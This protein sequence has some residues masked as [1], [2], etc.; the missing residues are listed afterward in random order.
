MRQI[1]THLI[2]LLLCGTLSAHGK[3]FIF[4]HYGG[5]DGL[6]ND[7]LHDITQDRQGFIWIATHYGISRFDGKMFKNYLLTDYPEMERDDFYHAFS[8]IDSMPLFASSYGTLVAYDKI[9]DRFIDYSTRISDSKYTGNITGIFAH[10]Q[11][12]K[13]LS[14]SDGIFSYDTQNG[15]FKPVIDS[16]ASLAFLL[17]NHQRRWVGSG[18]GL[19]VY[20][21]TGQR[22]NQFARLAEILEVNNIRQL[23]PNLI[24]LASAVSESYIVEMDEDGAFKSCTMLQTPFSRISEIVV[25]KEKTLWIGTAGNGLWYAPIELPLQFKKATPKNINE[26]LLKKISALYEDETGSIW[27]GTQNSG[28][29]RCTPIEQMEMFHSSDIGLSNLYCSSFLE[30][31]E[32]GLLVGTDGQGIWE[33]DSLYQGKRHLT[34]HNGLSSNSVLSLAYFHNQI[35][36]SSWGGAII[37]YTPTNNTLHTEPIRLNRPLLTI[38]SICSNG[39]DEFLAC[40]SG[41]GVYAYKKGEW[42]RV[43]LLLNGE[44]DKWTHAAYYSPREEAYW[45]LTSRTIWR[46]DAHGIRAILP[47][48]NLTPSHNPQTIHQC[49][50]DDEGTLWVVANNGI[51]TLLPGDSLLQ[52]VEYLPSGSYKSILRDKEGNLWCSGSNGIMRVNPQGRTFKTLYHLPNDND[53]FVERAIYQRE[54]GHLLFGCKNGFIVYKHDD[55]QKCATRYAEWSDLYIQN[56]R[57]APGTAPLLKPLNTDSEITVAYNQTNIR[58]CFDIVDFCNYN[59]WNV[60]YRIMGLDST[61][62]RLTQREININH[63]PIGSYL[64]E[65][66][67]K[68]DEFQ[69]GNIILRKSIEVVPAWWQ[70]IWLKIAILLLLG[71][72]A[73]LIVN[74][75]IRRIKRQKEELEEIVAERTHELDEKN[76]ILQDQNIEIESK[77][78]A[79]LNSMKEKDQLVSIIAHDLKNPMFAIVCG[80]EHA[81]QEQGDKAHSLVPIHHSATSLQ[82]EMVKLLDWATEGKSSMRCEMRSIDVAALT[83][84]IIL[85]LQGMSRE[86]EINITIE[87]KAKHC[88]IADEK[89][90]STIIRNLITNAIKFTPTGK[91]I[92]ID[93]YDEAEHLWFKIKDEGVG[94]SPQQRALLLN[95]TAPSTPGTNQEMGKGLGFKIIKDFIEKNNG[96]LYIESTEGEGTTISFRLDTSTE[97]ATTQRTERETA[98]SAPQL[99]ADDIKMLEGKSILSIDDDPLILQHLQTILAPYVE[100]HTATNGEEGLLK[101]KE[102]IPDLI[103][104]DVDM[105]QM[106]G[107][108]MFSLLRQNN[109]TSNIPLLFLSARRE[110]DIKLAGLANGALDYI[111]KPFDDAELLT[112]VR[113]I[114]LFLKRQQI[115]F[116]MERYNG[117]EDSSTPKE[118]ENPLLQ[119]LMDVIVAHYENPEFSFDDI[120]HAL[121]MS[122]STLTRRLKTLTDKSPVEILSEYRLNKAKKLLSEGGCNVSDV[123]YKVGFNDPLYFSKKFKDAFGVPPSKVMND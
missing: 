116:L 89:M 99:S 37:R 79:L 82:T 22:D 23:T 34:D 17:D 54:N 4:T 14:T 7:Y 52:P 53:Y 102:I 83:G 20:D 21:S 117:T 110:T 64:I 114:L 70:T 63:L 46:K 85:L 78:I 84:E 75:R 55:E 58:L 69:P 80:L 1:L 115:K 5:E 104:S 25:S 30:T 15:R 68:G 67:T 48:Q 6:C 39:K 41:D 33:V 120:A 62:T 109:C 56:K 100:V 13:F 98:A 122:K 50:C 90:L 77:N 118:E 59:A 27:I 26:D 12:G 38:K 119:Q 44:A 57:V 29:W 28:L 32:G 92:H 81:M 74:H 16:I 49:V 96:S 106:D 111:T 112:K 40:T 3:D 73:F 101:A 35:F 36:I 61:W 2:I 93:I 10:P 51:F 66:M 76:H 87:S 95:G 11:G 24:L 45:I 105:P 9:Q 91:S 8:S 113:N 108:Q 72:I 121:G 42:E 60:Q 103:I 31:P 88:A 43:P 94:M 123:A 86:K 47:D 19:F 71:G 97:E 107:L 18:D 65:V